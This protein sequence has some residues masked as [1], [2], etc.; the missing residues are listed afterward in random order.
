MIINKTDKF[1]FLNTE[2]ISTVSSTVAKKGELKLPANTYD[3]VSAFQGDPFV[4]HLSTPITTS[5]ITRTYLSLLP[6]YKQG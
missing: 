4:G 5:S 1:N 3:V 2:E 6:A